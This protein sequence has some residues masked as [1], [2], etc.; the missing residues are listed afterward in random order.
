MKKINTHLLILTFVWVAGVPILADDT[1]EKTE[2]DDPLSSIF[3]D[4]FELKAG[5]S[6]V[7]ENNPETGELRSMRMIGGVVIKSENM[8]ITCED[9][10][11][12]MERNIMIA[13]GKDG[14]AME[15]TN[16]DTRGTCAVM[17][18]DIETKKTVLEGS[19]K[20]RPVVY[21]MDPDGSTQIT[22]ADKITLIENDE[23]SNVLWEGNVVIKRVSAPAPKKEETPSGDEK[24]PP[25]RIDNG[26]R[27]APRPGNPG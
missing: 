27:R 24:P 5:G 7:A 12:D 25:V 15:F 8:D 2:S 23:K 1:P 20:T 19:S 18:Y 4:Q 22:E 17:N 14:N 10:Y 13:K 21:Q 26:A 6:V 3:G 11:I 9:M 16:G